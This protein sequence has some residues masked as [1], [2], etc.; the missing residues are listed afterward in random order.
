MAFFVDEEQVWKC[1]KH[2]SKRRSTGICPSCLRERLLT[3]CPECATNRPCSCNPLPPPSTSN[4]SSIFLFRF[5][6]RRDGFLPPAD[7]DGSGKSNITETEPAFRKS[8]SLAAPIGDGYDREFVEVE[9]KRLTNVSRNFWSVFKLSK[10]KKYDSNNLNDEESNKSPEDYSRMMRS[11]SV[12]VA[13]GDGFSPAP[14]KRRG[15]YLPSPMKAFR[16][17]KTSKLQLHERSPMHRG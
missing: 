15:W 4:S 17:T 13:A 7:T 12:A 14:A 1:P 2:P 6:G 3:L 10:T 5:S 16:Q 11:R 8:R 9:K